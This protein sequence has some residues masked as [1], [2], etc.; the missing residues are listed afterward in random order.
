MRK[1]RTPGENGNPDTDSWTVFKG[2]ENVADGLEDV[3]K[4]LV[5][6][7]IEVSSQQLA[8]NYGG[9]RLH[10]ECAKPYLPLRTYFSYKNMQTT[11]EFNSQQ[12]FD[13]SYCITIHR[14]RPL[15][16]RCEAYKVEV[17]RL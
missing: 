12:E 10:R 1:R 9:I 2:R 14:L 15:T 17:P 4:Y 13:F 6:F 11:F 16:E 5:N 3:C 7:G 8:H